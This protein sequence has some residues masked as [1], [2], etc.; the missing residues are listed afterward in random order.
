MPRHPR[1]DI[2]STGSH[3]QSSGQNVLR[4]VMVSVMRSAAVRAHPCPISQ[5]QCM[6]GRSTGTAGLG[7]WIEP[8]NLHQRPSIP[9]RFVSQ[10]TEKLSPAGIGNC[11]AVALCLQHTSNRQ[12]LNR[13]HLVFAD[14]TTRQ[15]VQEVLSSVADGRMGA[16]QF[17]FRL[18]SVPRA[19]L[20][21][22]QTALL[23]SQPLL[24]FGQ[25]TRV[26]NF[27]SGAEYSQTCQTEID[28]HRAATA[29]RLDGGENTAS[30][31]P[32][33][34]RFTD[35]R[36]RA[37]FSRKRTRPYHGQR[38]SH[39]CE[40][41]RAIAIGKAGP[42]ELRR[43]PAVFPAKLWIA[44]TF[45]KEPLV[46]C[47]KMTQ[48]LLER[49]ARNLLQP[50]ESRILFQRC[51]HRVGLQEPA[52]FLMVRPCSFPQ[53]AST[54]IDNTHAAE[55]SVQQVRLLRRRVETKTVGTLNEVHRVF[56]PRA[57]AAFNFCSATEQSYFLCRQQAVPSIRRA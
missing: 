20:F 28:S 24:V 8:I 36:D 18:Y 46:S 35:H 4:S 34:I 2:P 1:T 56:I 23:L 7:R 13:D 17:Q 31:V 32:T 16:C 11:T 41:E 45:K 57:A 44:G 33:P 39:F 10:L 47:L 37:R 22:R 43:L 21:A 49:N 27:F 53:C 54:V 48:T 5:C 25:I 29:Q 50:S 51:Q 6:S 38:L 9:S 26:G 12:C 30:D 15:L 52:P 40:R 19:F 42:G 55:C 3:R 14:Q